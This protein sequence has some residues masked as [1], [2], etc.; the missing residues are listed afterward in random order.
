MLTT[1]YLHATLEICKGRGKSEDIYFKEWGKD[2]REGY[3][4]F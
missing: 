1:K 3:L 2:S 4:A